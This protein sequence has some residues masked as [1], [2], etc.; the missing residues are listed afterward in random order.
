[1]ALNDFAVDT[2]R[3]QGLGPEWFS[4]T[5][6]RI[7]SEPTW[8][9][10]HAQQIAEWRLK[11]AATMEETADHFGKTVPTIRAA[12]REARVK[13][14]VDALGKEVSLSQRKCWSKEH[15]SDVAEYLRQPGATIR[16]AA[17]HFGKSEPTIS[18]AH[19]IASKP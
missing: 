4:V 14:G 10:S 18:K 1:M 17:A 11:N 19:R 3:F 9:E 2:T 13:H 7:A 15:A 16:Q 12:L 5:Q 8:R 6:F